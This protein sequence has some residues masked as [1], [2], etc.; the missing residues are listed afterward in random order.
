MYA[1]LTIYTQRLE[2]V[3]SLCE[4]G[5]LFSATIFFLQSVCQSSLLTVWRELNV[6]YIFSAKKIFVENASVEKQLVI[7]R[8]KIN[9]RYLIN[10]NNSDV[11]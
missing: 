2:T 10:L 11:S 3:R 9:Y 7:K 1:L 6:M 4:P 8:A 5:S